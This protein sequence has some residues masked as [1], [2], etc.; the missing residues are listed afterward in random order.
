[1]GAL[2]KLHRLFEEQGLQAADFPAA[3]VIHEALA[4]AFLSFTWCVGI[5]YRFATLACIIKLA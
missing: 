1:M 4:V 3:F 5:M 2:A